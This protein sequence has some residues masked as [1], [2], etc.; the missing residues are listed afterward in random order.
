MICPQVKEL[1]P[2]LGDGF[3][4]ACLEA[5]GPKP[6]EVV[7]RVLDGS[8]PPHLDELDRLL[9]VW[10]PPTDAKGKRRV[11]PAGPAQGP[12]AAQQA[13]RTPRQTTFSYREQQWQQQWR[14]QQSVSPLRH[15]ATGLRATLL[16]CFPHPSAADNHMACLRRPWP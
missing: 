3:V 10:P 6:E 14:R 15:A 7:G 11:E 12:S 16:H 5:L 8:L 9:T 2:D 4:A 1:L 13:P